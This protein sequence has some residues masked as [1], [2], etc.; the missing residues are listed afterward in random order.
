MERHRYI[1]I[2]RSWSDLRIELLSLVAQRLSFFDLVRFGVVCKSWRQAVLDGVL[3]QP[4]NDMPWCMNYAWFEHERKI[5]SILELSDLMARQTYS[6]GQIIRE[7]A[8]EL[9]VGAKVCASKKG[10]LL[11]SKKCTGH[12]CIFF[13]YS[14][15]C[16][17]IIELPPLESK[18]GIYE[19]AAT[20]T[21][22]PTS[23]DGC[24]VYV[25]FGC[26]DSIRSCNLRNRTWSTIT[27]GI[28]HGVLSP[29][30]IISVTDE[31]MI[32]YILMES[33]F[34]IFD[35]VIWVRSTELQV[36]ET[37]DLFPFLK[38]PSLQRQEWDSPSKSYLVEESDGK[39]Y[40]LVC[41][42]RVSYG[43]VFK[44]RTV[45][46]GCPLS[47]STDP[48]VGEAS[49]EFAGK[50]FYKTEIDI[51]SERCIKFQN[52]SQVKWDFELLWKEKEN[53]LRAAM[54]QLPD[55]I[56]YNK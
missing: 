51:L 3:G 48:L 46:Y 24:H 6:V 33:Y 40:W 45:F 12:S 47:I 53:L 14:P 16:N 44:K 5:I 30:L 21:K 4:V 39:P 29:F 50:T 7:E 28:E 41:W 26:D 43:E 31:Y 10:W 36:W 9:F 34:V 56:E 55:S 27:S 17:K 2:K 20:F 49:D 11:L 38:T 52:R 54:I 19:H 25:V 1:M 22:V 8:R 18:C 15:F 23:P 13:F 35:Q 42:V 32:W 37:M